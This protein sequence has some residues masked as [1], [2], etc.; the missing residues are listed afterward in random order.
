MVLELTREIVRENAEKRLSEIEA[1]FD[2]PSFK[3]G[4][5]STLEI[6]LGEVQRQALEEISER[7]DA[8]GIGKTS[9]EGLTD[10][11]ETAREAAEYAINSG[12]ISSKAVKLIKYH[13][14]HLQMIVLNLE[15]LGER[16]FWE[17]YRVLFSS[18]VEIHE[19]VFKDEGGNAEFRD[20]VNRML[21]RLLLGSSLAANAVTIG[22]SAVQLLT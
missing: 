11:F 12:K 16:D 13:I 5:K 8:Q 15:S 18:F 20:R 6:H 4:T 14:S 22:T 7:L 3:R 17:H 1:V 10:A 2:A 21:G 9:A 19:G